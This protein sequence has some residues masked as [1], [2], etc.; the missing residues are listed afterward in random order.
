MSGNAL[1]SRIHNTGPLQ[2]TP[3]CANEFDWPV[4]HLPSYLLQCCDV[5]LATFGCYILHFVSVNTQH[6]LLMLTS[7]GSPITL[8]MINAIDRRT[9][10]SE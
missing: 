4:F 7:K 9:I 1:W 2:S 6:L 5:F 3:A 10:I 8:A